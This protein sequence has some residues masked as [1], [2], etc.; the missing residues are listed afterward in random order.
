MQG[1]SRPVRGWVSFRGRR[2]HRPGA[3]SAVAA[4][5]P[6]SR[7]S[8]RPRA[9]TRVT[10]TRTAR[11]RS[12]RAADEQSRP[13]SPTRCDYCEGQRYPLRSRLHG[14]CGHIRPDWGDRSCGIQSRWPERENRCHRTIPLRS[15]SSKPLG[16][17]WRWRHFGEVRQRR[18]S[19]SVSS[20]VVRS[21]RTGLQRSYADIRVG[22]GGRSTH[23]RDSPPSRCGAT[24]ICAP[25]GLVETSRLLSG[26]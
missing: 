11:C 8:A 15:V 23:W 1:D 7:T 13:R 22:P 2:R 21:G 4:S 3:P 17:V 19:A 14:P 18:E 20:V 24:V 10:A 12:T 16:A 5:G 25:T 9:G 6:S 26:L